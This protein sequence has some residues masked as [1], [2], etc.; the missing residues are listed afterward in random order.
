MARAY[1]GR[2]I[3]RRKLLAMI[4]SLS[5]FSRARSGLANTGDEKKL[6][7]L[8]CRGG[9]DAT[10]VFDP[11]F[12][13]SQVD[14]PQESDWAEY[15]GISFA[16]SPSRPAVDSF[17][18]NFGRRAVIVN[19]IAVGSISH[20]KCEQL[21]FSGAR[22]V[23]GTDL[24]TM[25]AAKSNTLLP[26]VV[27][28]GPRLQGAYGSVVTP[29][30]DLFS[31]LLQSQSSD[32]LD[33]YLQEVS[34]G[35]SRLEQEYHNSLKR[36]ADIRDYAGLINISDQPTVLEQVELAISLFSRGLSRCATIE[37]DLPQR[38][39]WDSHIDNEGNQSQCF[40][41]LFSR[42]STIVQKFEGST[43]ENGVPL[44]QNTVVAVLS[45]MGRTPKNNQSMGKD[46]WPYTSALFISD[47]F[48][49]G[50]VLGQS[51]EQLV[52]NPLDFVTGL[53]QEDGMTLA[54]NNLL[55]GIVDAFGGDVE[56]FFPGVPLFRGLI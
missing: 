31:S 18:S 24:P 33:T 44:L 43:D 34:Q 20:S 3:S 7:V 37:M 42:L 26:H 12:S 16:S 38:V 6:L 53:P 36:R 15:N 27:L 25:I 52:G 13:S 10:M 39:G 19:G 47:A 54:A 23:Q 30:D 28:S 32:L 4:P 48:D 9:W 56:R 46:H 55:A 35:E 51:N 49:G 14:S 1:G 5:L 21:L 17:F 41:H 29:L 8:F 40:Q 50:R 11:H 45:E 22:G 2:M